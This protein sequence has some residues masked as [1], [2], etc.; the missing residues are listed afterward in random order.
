MVFKIWFSQNIRALR[1]WTSQGLATQIK[2]LFNE[3]G[4]QSRHSGHSAQEFDFSFETLIECL[5]E[6]DYRI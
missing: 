1:W 2:T 3:L 6:D 4:A 5:L